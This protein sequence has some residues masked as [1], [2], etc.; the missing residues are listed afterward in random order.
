VWGN[1]LFSQFPLGC[2]PRVGHFEE[3]WQGHTDP[4]H[5]V[6]LVG[7]VDELKQ[8]KLLV[9]HHRQC[10]HSGADQFV[11]ESGGGDTES[12]QN[13]VIFHER[14]ELGASRVE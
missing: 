7:I 2:I 14:C 6:K 3:V 11:G 12:N 10:F 13:F 4:K 5:D 9:F 1:S 8:R